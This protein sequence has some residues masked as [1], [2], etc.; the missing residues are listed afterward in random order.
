MMP[1]MRCRPCPAH[2]LLVVF[3][4]MAAGARGQITPAD[5]G[6]TPQ[7]AAG[8]TPSTATIEVTRARS[9]PSA[10]RLSNLSVRAVAGGAS[11]PLVAGAAI[12]GTGS[13]PMLARA[14]G[15]GLRQFGVSGNLRDPSLELF[16]GTASAARTTAFAGDAMAASAYV[17]AFPLQVAPASDAALL[18]LAATGTLTAHCASLSNTPGVALLE[19]YDATAAP[20][21]ASPRFTNFSSR[22]RVD[23]GERLI[24]VGF[25]VAGEGELRLLLRGV[26]PTLEQFNVTGVLADPAIELYA[27][28]DRIA[29]NDDW[30][31]G[32]AETTAAL[33]GAGR[34]VGAFD[35]ASPSDAA[36]LVSLRAG[37]YTLLVHGAPGQS[38]TAL[39]EIYEAVAPTTGFDAGRSIN[40]IGMD[41]FRLVAA[42]EGGNFAVSPYSAQSALAMTYCGAAGVTRTEMARVL[43]YPDDSA[44]VQAAFADLRTSLETIAQQSIALAQSRTT[45]STH[46][47]PIEW[48]AANRIFGQERYV[49]RDEFLTLMRGGFAAPVQMLD[50]KRAFEPARTVINNWVAEQT[51]QKILDLIPD[52]GLNDKTRMVL[53]NA[54]YL[55]APWEVRFKTS[56]TLP[57]AFH[58]RPTTTKNVPTMAQTSGMGYSAED[59]MQVVTLD[60]L[61]RELQFVIVLPD[62]GQTPDTAAA[63][64][65]PA[66]LARWSKLGGIRGQLVA[67]FLPKFKIQGATFDLRAALVQL[68]MT[69]AFDIPEESANFTGI[70]PVQYFEAADPEYLKLDK[71]FQK[72][73]VYVEE[74]GTEAAAATAAIV[75]SA[76][77]TSVGVA[78]QPIVVRV[79]RPFLFAIQHRASGACLFIRRV[80]APL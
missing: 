61:G 51:R 46:V 76:V 14:I 55:K 39:A 8:W 7:A 15:P 30:R 53:V 71:V 62:E 34:A 40:A 73:Y 54:I 1:A 67:L 35:L 6:G 11:S 75:G 49:F 72:T 44:V 26:G 2:A 78:P 23:A 20:T 64:I 80:N 45:S 58:P 38:G 42:N 3:V 68:G 19:F 10:A 69:T 57:R 77:I 36:L 50:F 52:G 37:S 74:S 59:G 41:L 12:Q 9:N 66:H 5:P 60:Y 79:E 28:G 17:G 70:A 48:N 63:R 21:A 24:V 32:G 13:L 4:V 18:G 56:D 47:D 22:A 33:Q 16:R 25:V 65:T 43:R 31:S 27:G 29:E